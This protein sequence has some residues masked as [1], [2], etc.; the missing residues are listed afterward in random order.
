MWCHLKA[1]FSLY[2]LEFCFELIILQDAAKL[3]LLTTSLRLS[4]D[5]SLI[6][7]DYHL[8]LASLGE[9]CK[10]WAFR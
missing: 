1:V 7:I 4:Q 6:K 10:N 2:L 3:Y 8:A 5:V 9:L